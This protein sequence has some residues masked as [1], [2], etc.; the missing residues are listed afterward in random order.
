MQLYPHLY[1][2]LSDLL[3]P[4]NLSTFS[5]VN[6]IFMAPFNI[7]LCSLNMA[8]GN[9]LYTLSRNL[10]TWEGKKEKPLRSLVLSL[11]IYVVCF[12]FIFSEF[13]SWIINLYYRRKTQFK[14]VKKKLYS[15]WRDCP[16][17]KEL[18]SRMT[19]YYWID[20]YKVICIWKFVIINI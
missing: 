7:L 10:Y 12:D 8:L 13:K 2:L 9:I 11:F 6:T 3:R 4:Y 1:S 17:H 15:G 14:F 18:Y 19:N 20:F 5:E 16:Y